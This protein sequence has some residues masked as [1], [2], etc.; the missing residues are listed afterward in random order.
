[1]LFFSIING[2]LM[3]ISGIGGL[4]GLLPII[5]PFLIGLV[6]GLLIK[7]AL[8]LAIGIV[9]LA[10]LLSWG[11]YAGFPSV[12]ELF[13]K[14]QSTLPALFGKGKGLLNTLPFTAPAFIIGLL[15]GIW[16]Q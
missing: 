7:T 10:V 13:D 1:M 14:A 5:V 16:W 6:V 11:G 8:K 4:E 9:A 12:R 3:A 15:I 2:D